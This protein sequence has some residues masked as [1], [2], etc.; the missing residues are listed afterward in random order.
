MMPDSGVKG[1]ITPIGTTSTVVSRPSM[2][3]APTPDAPRPDVQ[4]R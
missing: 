4:E 3:G 2:L 1:K